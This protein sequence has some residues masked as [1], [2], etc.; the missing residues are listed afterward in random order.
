[1][2][3]LVDV[4]GVRKSFADRVA[5]DGVDLEIGAGEIFGLLGPNGAGKTTLLRVLLDIYDADEGEIR[6]CGKPR[7][8][9]DLETIGY[10]PE[11]RGI[12][13]RQTV[14]EGLVYLGELKGLSAPAAKLQALGLLA[15]LHILE[16][17]QR[18]VEALSKGNQQRVQILGTL[19]GAPRLLI[20]DEPFSGLDPHGVVELSAVLRA[21]VAEGRTVL[22]STHLMPQ[23]EALCDRVALLARG[24]VVLQGPV[25]ELR[26]REPV[27]EVEVE[28]VDD[29]G[30]VSTRREPVGDRLPEELLA[31]IL[32]AG[33]RV[34]AFRPRQASLEEIFLRAVGS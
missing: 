33:E 20:W 19:M 4:R 7:T 12:Y 18:K 24:R 22:L 28:V 31:T 5:L 15:R 34:R 23:A 27:R 26:A 13:R 8:R 3:A 32:A 1:M 21:L 9:T 6:W 17:A 14:L 10:L 11:E 30:R 16:H 25:A 29:E 2:N